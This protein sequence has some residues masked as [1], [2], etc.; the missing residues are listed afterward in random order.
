VCCGGENVSCAEECG[1]GFNGS[2]RTS[3]QKRDG[4]SN[5]GMQDAV[6]ANVFGQSKSRRGG[7]QLVVI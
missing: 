4:G 7:G 1:E 2:K 6:R 5:T 3:E